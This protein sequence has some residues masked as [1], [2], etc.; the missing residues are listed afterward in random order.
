MST[1][2]VMYKPRPRAPKRRTRTRDF[3][4][5]SVNGGVELSTSL[6]T[7]PSQPWTDSNWVQEPGA[8]MSKSDDDSEIGGGI[9]RTSVGHGAPKTEKSHH[10]PHHM[11][12]VITTS[13]RK[14]GKSEEPPKEDKKRERR[15]K[16]EK[17]DNQHHSNADTESEGESKNGGRAKTGRSASK[18]RHGKEYHTKNTK[19]GSTGD[20][21]GSIEL[22]RGSDQN[23]L[24]P[25][26]EPETKPAPIGSER[27]QRKLNGKK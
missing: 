23:F 2:S 13:Q 9:R 6:A 10:K 20:K 18:N 1:D 14:H 25:F 5:D 16:R 21:L 3:T 27:N 12:M 7:S 19:R 26:G 15:N 17:V 22:L 24:Y 11:E 4:A 8:Y